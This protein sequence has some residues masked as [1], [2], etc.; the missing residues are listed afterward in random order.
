MKAFP[1]VEALYTHIR[2]K[3]HADFIVSPELLIFNFNYASLFHC[4]LHL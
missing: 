1:G 4:L 3:L 2:K